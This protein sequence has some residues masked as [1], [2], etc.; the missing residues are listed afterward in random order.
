MYTI[1]IN[2]NN[3][4]MLYK[5]EDAMADIHQLCQDFIKTCDEGNGG[6]YILRDNNSAVIAFY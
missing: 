1:R 3:E 6:E 4:I 2:E 5:H